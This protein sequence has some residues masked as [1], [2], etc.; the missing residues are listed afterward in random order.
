MPPPRP[1]GPGY[2]IH[3]GPSKIGDRAHIAVI[4]THETENPK[5]GPMMQAWILRADTHPVAAIAAGLDTAI[6][7]RCRLRPRTTGD[8]TAL[9]GC[10]VVAVQG[11]ASVWRSYQ[12][13]H[14]PRLHRSRLARTYVGQTIR[15][16]A[17]GDPAAAPTDLWGDL[18]SELAGW[19]GY[20]HQWKRRPGL[21]H[22][23]M[24]SVE[25]RADRDRANSM[26][27]GTFRPL[28][29]DDGPDP[30]ERRCPAP[31]VTC[32]DCGLCHGTGA[33][34][35][36]PAHGGKGRIIASARAILTIRGEHDTERMAG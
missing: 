32:H 11:P 31:R 3:E 4:V 8:P 27:F 17:Y 28:S 23:V 36:I 21:R 18:T 33:S 7:G 14:Y 6:C 20:T 16:G 22:Y 34:I 30:F 26:G 10:Y 1:P 15:L 24:A 29:P 2:V 19:T 9:G 35:T 25:S 13:N 5:T 12:A